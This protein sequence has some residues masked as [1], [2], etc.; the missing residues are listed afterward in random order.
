LNCEVIDKL[1][2]ELKKYEG[3]N[4]KITLSGIISMELMTIII[5]STIDEDKIKLILGDENKI[6]FNMHQLAKIIIK[7]E[8]LI[9]FDQLQE[10]K[11]KSLK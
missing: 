9:Y 4:I 10:V 1:Q 7:D 8:I 3:K 5:R 6:S 2:G 11:I